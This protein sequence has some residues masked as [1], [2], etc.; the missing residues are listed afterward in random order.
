[1]RMVA[2]GPSIDA[3][4]VGADA[5]DTDQNVRTKAGMHSP[6]R[7]TGYPRTAFQRPK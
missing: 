1:M 6:R 3:E 2:A 5:D 4:S 7:Y